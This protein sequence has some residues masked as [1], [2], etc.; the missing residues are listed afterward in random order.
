M[1]G[2][3]VQASRCPKCG[4]RL[5]YEELNSYGDIYGVSP[6]TGKP[7]KKRRRRQFYG[8]SDDQMLYCM[9]C[10]TNYDFRWRDDVLYLYYEP[11]EDQT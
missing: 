4:G 9:S 2:I 3:S 1:N 10:G 8:G 7:Y 11:K 5:L 6:K